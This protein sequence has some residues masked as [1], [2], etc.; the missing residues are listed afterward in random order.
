MSEKIYIY[1][2]NKKAFICKAHTDISDFKKMALSDKEFET[3]MQNC[4][5]TIVLGEAGKG[6][7]TKFSNE[8]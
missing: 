3:I 2:N 5:T 4:T 8:S 6:K 1:I 7:E